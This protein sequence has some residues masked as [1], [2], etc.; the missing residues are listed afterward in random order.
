MLKHT[1]I[2]FAILE[3]GRIILKNYILNLWNTFY[4][5]LFFILQKHTDNFIFRTN[6]L[7]PLLSP[8]YV[9]GTMYM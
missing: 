3:F 6:V 7:V 4:H 2:K 5:S 1:G 8:T 9:L